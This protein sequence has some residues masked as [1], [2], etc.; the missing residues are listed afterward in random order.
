MAS[1]L[2]LSPMTRRILLGIATVIGLA[3][4][5]FG[6]SAISSA[7]KPAQ[8]TAKTTQLSDEARADIFANQALAAES[9][10]DTVTA[11]SLAESA[12]KLNAANQTAR[13]VIT[14]LD[15][16][17]Q[18]SAPATTT[19][20]PSTNTSSS[21]DVW[22]QPAKSLAAM[23]PKTLEGWDGGNVVSQGADAQVTYEPESGTA[24][25]S[26]AI[27]ATFSV[28]DRGTAAKASAFVSAVDKKVYPGSGAV[29]KFG[30]QNGYFGTDGA[31]LAVAAF[32]RGR[33]AFEV[34]IYSQ[35]G[36]KPSM[37]LSLATKLAVAFP[38]AQ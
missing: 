2:Q 30:T 23:L 15:D 37:L 17:A 24:D 26:S 31:R 20:K 28:H 12:L 16:A 27:R 6:V 38:A 25:E 19:P 14:R 35:Q 33:F 4:L 7:R 21:G 34:V 32:S 13:S 11:R 9:K 3:L 18:H 8:T 36:I 29:T 1:K 22:S 10:D 5:I